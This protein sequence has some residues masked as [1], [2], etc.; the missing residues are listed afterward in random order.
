MTRAKSAALSVPLDSVHA[1]K[2]PLQ[3]KKIATTSQQDAQPRKRAALGDVSNV[4]KGAALQTDGKKQANPTT[5]PL[6]PSQKVNRSNST[7][8]ILGAK[9]KNSGTNDLKRQASTANLAENVAKK[10]TT[11]SNSSHSSTHDQSPDDENTPPFEDDADVVELE[12]IETRKVT[13]KDSHGTKVLEDTRT[14]Q[15]ILDPEPENKSL[16]EITLDSDIRR[17]DDEDEGDPL[18]V[19]EYVYEIIQYMRDIESRT[20]PNANYMDNQK[21]LEWRMRGILVD[22]LLEVHTRF[23][24]LPETFYLTVNIIDRFLSHKEVGLE[25]LQLVGVTAMFIASKYEEVLS[26]HIGNFVHVADEGFSEG[27]ILGAERYILQ[28]LNY[29]L[30][31]PNPMHFMRRISKADNYEIQ[32][33]TLAKYLLEISLLD[34][35]FLKHKPSMNA[36]ASMYLSRTILGK[37]P[38][39]G[40]LTHY[41]GYTE[42]EIQPVFDLMLDYLRGPITHS[43]FY[44]KYAGKKFLK[45]QYLI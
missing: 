26:P 28:V 15:H 19:S 34:H 24:L 7:R 33:R 42:E 2:K 13:K 45:G 3:A 9:D 22:W 18:M 35:R 17:L 12:I 14:E 31:F 40:I 27:E 25:K 44:K 38:W 36:A 21:H 4:N 30:S 10:R 20:Q 23:H 1:N 41:S 29:D 32:T 8:N 6:Q 37:G 39:D 43:A 11:T 5:K 16:D